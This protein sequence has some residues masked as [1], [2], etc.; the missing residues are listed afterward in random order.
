MTHPKFVHTV[1][2]MMHVSRM[3]LVLVKTPEGVR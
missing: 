3:L 2:V 1:T